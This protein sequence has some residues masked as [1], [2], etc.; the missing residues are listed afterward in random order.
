M[1]IMSLANSELD[2]LINN[3]LLEVKTGFQFQVPRETEEGVVIDN[4]EYR[5]RDLF[6]EKLRRAEHRIR[7]QVASSSYDERMYQVAYSA[8]QMGRCGQPFTDLDELLK[9]EV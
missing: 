9:K 6:K 5:L 8:Y 2:R 7:L 1:D 3:T 4:Y